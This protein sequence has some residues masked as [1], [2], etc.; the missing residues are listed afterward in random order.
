M[1]SIFEN[2][3]EGVGSDIEAYCP[4]PRCKADTNHTVISKYEDEIRRVQCVVCG[5]VHAYRKPRGEAYEE[6]PEPPAR[7]ARKKP[8]WEQFMATTTA[9]AMENCR[10]YSIRDTYQEGDLVSHP[11]FHVGFVSELLPDNKVEITFRDDRRI[12][13]HNRADLAAKMPA[14]AEIPMPR[15]EKRRKRKRKQEPAAKKA[16]IDLKEL[17]NLEEDPQ[18]LEEKEA[19]AE[20]AAKLKLASEREKLE[21]KLAAERERRELEQKRLEQERKEQERE[22]LRLEK[23]KERERLRLEKEKERER[24]RLEKEKEREK[25][26]KEKEREKAR[27]E[28]E[29]E[30]LR[31]QKERERL[32]KLREREK[33]RKE[34]EREKARK[35]KE[36]EK[37]RK[38]KERERLRKEKER[39]KA[40]KVKAA[41]V[42][43]KPKAAAKAKAKPSRSKPATKAKAAPKPK[44]APTTKSASIR[45]TGGKKSVPTAQAAAKKRNAK[46]TKRGR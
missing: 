19:V 21:K 36:R 38:E 2:D 42:S 46:A 44:A 30:R 35:E 6:P 3:T 11:T 40:R 37:A 8:T 4:S 14:V 45:R 12:L 1:E 43:A 16:D 33:A 32:Q 20:H 34:K 23:E 26:R 15:E 24:L 39:E 7:K 31:K 41:K 17:L 5:D 9:K 22:R 27:N 13:V 25:A 29:R 10:P 28:K 18:T